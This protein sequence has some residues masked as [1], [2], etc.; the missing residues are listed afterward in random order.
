MLSVEVLFRN[1]K[2]LIAAGY[3]E[4]CENYPQKRK[5]ERKK[6]CTLNRWCSRI[7]SYLELVAEFN[8]R[9]FLEGNHEKTKLRDYSLWTVRMVQSNASRLQIMESGCE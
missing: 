9:N 6:L 1:C 7:H 8:V 5:N 3:C 4:N 2:H